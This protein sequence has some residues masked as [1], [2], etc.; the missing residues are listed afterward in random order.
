MSELSSVE[1]E[2]E[3]PTMREAA[4]G[5]LLPKWFTAP[6]YVVFL[7]LSVL[8]VAYVVRSMH[9]QALLRDAVAEINLGAQDGA[10]LDAARQREV[11]E[12]LKT[13]PVDSFLYL[14]QEVLQ[15]EDR[16]PRMARAMALRKAAGWGIMSR[17]RAVVEAVLEHM[18]DDGA[19][20]EG[21]ELDDDARAVLRDLADERAANPELSYAEDRVTDVVAWLADGAVEPPKGPEKRRMKALLEQYQKRS[22][23]GTEAEALGWLAE[24]WH[25]RTE[26]G[27]QDAAEQFR[28]MLA[29]QP[30]E[31][32]SESAAL[33]LAEADGWE[34]LYR[35][36]MVRLANTARQMVDQIVAEGEFLD[37]PH[38]YQYLSLLEHR[39]EEVRQQVA[40]GIWLLRHDR[41]AG[42]F[43]IRF[44]SYFA[45]KT[46][47]NS[48]LAVATMRL[49]RE[50]N[51]RQMRRANGRRMREAVRLLGRI[52][53][54]YIQNPDAYAIDVRKPG[55]FVQTQT[56]G[57]LESVADE[58]TIADLVA[59]ALAAMRQADMARPGGL[60][61]FV[62]GAGAQS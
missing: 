8:G 30:A 51:E 18:G 43:V 45:T 21:F 16:D 10:E 56:V 60:L 34:E 1:Q 38:I 24:E 44:T 2:Q 42:E 4:T 48:S 9:V 47:I 26:P 57:A 50:E 31:L 28:L 58:E 13:R 32:S 12:L 27:A 33:C 3:A 35:Q 49:T 41:D 15:D 61:F 37:H 23:M 7:L 46:A 40:E 25:G 5:P 6:F 59:E 14:N 52:G 62:E 55:E 39:F 17:R 22:F 53:V 54:D 11:I 19:L 36:G 20:E 29:D